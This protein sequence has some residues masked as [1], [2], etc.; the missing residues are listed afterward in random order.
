MDKI[1]DKNVSVIFLEKRNWKLIAS[2]CKDVTIW[3]ICGEYGE[4]GCLYS[5]KECVWICFVL[6]MWN[7]YYP[8][9]VYVFFQKH[10]Y[11]VSF[12]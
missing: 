4:F 9:C 8:V 7:K 5:L 12:H 11:Y 3:T 10:D 2:L 1:Y 6:E